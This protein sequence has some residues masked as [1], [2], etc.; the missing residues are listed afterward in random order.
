MLGGYDV[1]DVALGVSLATLVLL[2][3]VFTMLRYKLLDGSKASARAVEARLAVKL[4]VLGAYAKSTINVTTA[5]ETATQTL[6]E[7]QSP[8]WRADPD[9]QAQ[10]AEVSF[11]SN[12]LARQAHERADLVTAFLDDG[13]KS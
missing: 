11:V 8:K 6:L 3:L 2:F 9:L 7:L 5:L 12:A 10:R 13:K 1:A 4:S